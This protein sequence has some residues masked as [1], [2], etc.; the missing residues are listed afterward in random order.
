MWKELTNKVKEAAARGEHYTFTQWGQRL[1]PTF[2]QKRWNSH[3]NSWF[4]LAR[5]KGIDIC[6]DVQTKELY[7]EEEPPNGRLI[8]GQQIKCSNSKKRQEEM[9]T[10]QGQDSILDERINAFRNA[11]AYRVKADPKRMAETIA[12]IDKLIINVLQ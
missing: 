6:R 5:A 2:P 7:C 4:T 11:L 12:T 8:E 3:A 10:I 9:K 1:R